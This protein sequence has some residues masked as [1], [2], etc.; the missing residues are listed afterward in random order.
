MYLRQIPYEYLQKKLYFRACW[1]CAKKM[2]TAARGIKIITP[3]KKNSKRLNPVTFFVENKYDLVKS[4]GQ[5]NPLHKPRKNLG[6][7]HEFI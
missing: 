1:V 2:L 5:A 4:A 7:N 3:Y 6:G